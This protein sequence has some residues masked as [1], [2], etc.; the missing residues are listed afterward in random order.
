MN[1]I[2]H[3]DPLTQRTARTVRETLKDCY[4]WWEG[5]REPQ[6]VIGHSFPGSRRVDQR[7]RRPSRI[8]CR[9]P[10]YSRLLRALAEFV[11]SPQAF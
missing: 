3:R 6:H 1:H 7:I 5:P 2:R 4:D 11:R 10:W 9:S 8:R